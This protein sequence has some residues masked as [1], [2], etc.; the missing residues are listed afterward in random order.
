MARGPIEI[1][2]AVDTGGIEKSIKNGLIDPVEDA[3]DALKKLGDTD[4][5]RD[6]DRQLDRAQDATEDFKDELDKTRKSLDKL[7]YAAKDAGDDASKGMGKFN[8]AAEEVTNEVGSNLGEAV[9]SIRGDLGDLG[10]VGQDTLGG[11]AATLAGTGPAGIAGAAGLAAGAVGL[12]LITDALTTQQEEADRLKDRLSDAYSGALQA[13]RDYLDG[14]DIIADAQDLAFNPDRKG[15]YEKVLETQKQTGLDIA[16]ILKA[17]AGEL[18]SIEIVQGRINDLWKNVDEVNIFEETFG[19]NTLSKVRDYW[20]TTADAASDYKQRAT[21]S[22]NYTSD[23]LLDYIDN[24]KGAE[25]QTNKFGDKLVTLPDGKEIV[26][27]AKT[28]KA[29]ENVD[30][31]R[32][33]VD[34]IPKEKAVTIRGTVD[35]DDVTRGIQNYR[36][37]RVTVVVD[38]KTRYGR[39]VF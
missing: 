27:D 10:Q 29:T 15:E 31:F 20:N 37:P 16:T 6:L 19:G 18:E 35:L 3:E 33:N 39:E 24:A 5:G 2:I 7:S 13:G 9:S 34:K 21:E 1:P 36:P 22:L 8:A 25:V 14:L 30:S 23:L 11:L 26:I 17:N 12:G 38:G 32:G 28:G 4:A